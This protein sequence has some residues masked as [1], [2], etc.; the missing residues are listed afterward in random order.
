MRRIRLDLSALQEDF[1]KLGVGL[2]LAGLV[3]WLLQNGSLNAIYA[4]LAGMLLL[5]AGIVRA[6]EDE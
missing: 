6:Q 1:R 4:E 2:M 5:F 3:G